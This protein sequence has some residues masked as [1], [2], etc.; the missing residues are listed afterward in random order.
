MWLTIPFGGEWVESWSPGKWQVTDALHSMGVNN[1][2][3]VARAVRE[4]TEL[5]D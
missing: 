4:V 1:P 5:A 3:L 2:E